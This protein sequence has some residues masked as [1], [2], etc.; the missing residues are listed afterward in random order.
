MGLHSPNRLREGSQPVTQCRDPRLRCGWHR[1]RKGVNT[2]ATSKS[3][4]HACRLAAFYG[5][6]PFMEAEIDDKLPPTSSYTAEGVLV[7]RKIGRKP[8][9]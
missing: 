1:D 3:H 8:I 7:A 6:L 2:L 5:I 9:K 4:E